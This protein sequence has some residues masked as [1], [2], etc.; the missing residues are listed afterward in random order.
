MAWINV[1]PTSGQ[2]NGTI[3]VTCEA[4][5]GRSNRMST[6]K[7]TTTSSGAQATC[8]CT[9]QGVGLQVTVFK[10]PVTIPSSGERDVT[11]LEANAG[12]PLFTNAYKLDYTA[13]ITTSGGSTVDLD[14]EVGKSRFVQIYYSTN[15]GGA[16]TLVPESGIVPN[17]P[18]ATSP[19]LYKFT[20]PFST[21]G[22]SWDYKR[23]IYFTFQAWD[24]NSNKETVEL[25]VTVEAVEVQD[26]YVPLSTKVLHFTSASEEESKIVS[27]IA[28][29]SWGLCVV[30]DTRY[31]GMA[32]AYYIP[33]DYMTFSPRKGGAT[34]PGATG[35]IIIVTSKP[36]TGTGTTV[37]K[38]RLRY[39]DA[40]TTVVGQIPEKS[41][42]ECTVY[43]EGSFQ[44]IQIDGVSTILSDGSHI[45]SGYSN[46]SE[47]KWNFRMTNQNGTRV[48]ADQYFLDYVTVTALDLDAYGIGT[49]KT[50]EGIIPGNKIVY[51]ESDAQ[52]YLGDL[53]AYK[54]T[55]RID[56]YAF[57]QFS[58]SFD[59]QVS[60][61]NYN[62]ATGVW[63]D[64]KTMTI[65]INKS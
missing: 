20:F 62:E 29:K 60:V 33:T 15:S 24:E 14:T 11:V 58:Y 42:N 65:L 32:K 37:T 55:M 61:A 34:P 38:F 49:G 46:G 53:N 23:I 2:G 56:S 35:D 22:I 52:Y 7:A 5:T 59:L 3:S 50:I 30:E 41:K 31:N 21:D 18:G 1:T 40:G 26:D 44:L 57:K 51:P 64:Y 48:N 25:T 6:I 17:D 19:Y 16:W 9:Q 10:N 36:M 47:M 4:T 39:D 12:G 54:Y 8:S 28:P 45:V 43:R 13:T 27:C 63:S